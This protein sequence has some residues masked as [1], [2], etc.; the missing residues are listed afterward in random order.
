M[1]NNSDFQTSNK[2]SAS[3]K[4]FL[5][6]DTKREKP[7]RRITFNEKMRKMKMLSDSKAYY[8][9][10]SNFAEKVFQKRNSNKAPVNKT[11][12]LEQRR[13]TS[14]Q[15]SSKHRNLDS[16]GSLSPSASMIYHNSF[17]KSNNYGKGRRDDLSG[18]ELNSY[19]H[20]SNS[21]LNMHH[22]KKRKMV[23]SR[24]ARGIRMKITKIN[25]SS[26]PKI[27]SKMLNSVSI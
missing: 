5:F 9:G 22:N 12:M 14:Q 3:E 4:I 20:S 17:Y 16:K 1:L 11:F 27:T 24:D 10:A 25:I 8:H 18:N 6:S 21:N 26:Q 15:N 7:L 19:Y 23:K 2:N 13:I